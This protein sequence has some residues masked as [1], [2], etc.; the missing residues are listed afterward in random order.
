MTSDIAISIGEA[1]LAA[2][3][4]LAQAAGRRQRGRK[5]ANRSEVIRE[6]V[7]EFLARKR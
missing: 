4:R 6:A 7:K 5:T 2:V 3:A 1:S